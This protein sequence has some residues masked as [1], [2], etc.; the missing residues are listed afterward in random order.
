MDSTPLQLIGR[1][2][3]LTTGIPQTGLASEAKNPGEV[4]GN[5]SQFLTE[6]LQTTSQLQQSSEQNIQAY[7][8]GAD[9]PLHQVMIGMEKA[10]SAMDLMLQM[11]NKLVGA[12]QEL[13]RMQF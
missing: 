9:I 3:D 1:F 7:A 11:R 5:F 2:P 8:S 13:S 10:G 6:Q 4:L 12:Y